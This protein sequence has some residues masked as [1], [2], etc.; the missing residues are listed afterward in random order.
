MSSYFLNEDNSPSSPCVAPPPPPRP[1]PA[2]V[3]RPRPCAAAPPAR[4]RALAPPRAAMDEEYDV[5]VLG[6]GLKEC[7]LSGLLSVD[8]L[9]APELFTTTPALA[10][11]KAIANTDMSLGRRWS[12]STCS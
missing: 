11:P 9:K 7:I 3:R 12:I 10:I 5:I 2:P 4:P 8:G 1:A 6:T